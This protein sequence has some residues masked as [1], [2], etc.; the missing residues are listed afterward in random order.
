F[1][2]VNLNRMGMETPGGSSNMLASVLNYWTP[3]NPTNTMTGLGIAPSSS[4]MTSRWV[5]D[6][7][8]IRLQNVTLQ[9]ELPAR[10]TDHFSMQH[11]A[12]GAAAGLLSAQSVPADRSGSRD[13][14]GR[15]RQLVH[16]RLE[17]AVLHSRLA[18]SHGSAVRP[19]HYHP[20][21][22]LALR[23]GHVHAHR[24]ERV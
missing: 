22:R 20:D 7:S 13:R 19:D 23:A 5:E 17:P 11:L 8:F 2:I 24:V 9:W 4:I 16:G 15:D 18:D 3:T 12:D 10:W 1:Q 21:Q 14:L 6:G